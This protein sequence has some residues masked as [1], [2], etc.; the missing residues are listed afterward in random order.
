[1]KYLDKYIGY[2]IIKGSFVQY[3][4]SVL[5]L[6]GE[7][8]GNWGQIYVLILVNVYFFYWV[9]SASFYYYFLNYKYK[10][11]YYIYLFVYI[12]EFIV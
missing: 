5:F 1:M 3:L 10:N 2:K 9:V 12:V 8:R 6:G 4:N 11:I 7:G